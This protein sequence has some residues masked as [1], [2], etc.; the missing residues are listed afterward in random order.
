MPQEQK[1]TQQQPGPAG[2]RRCARLRAPSHVVR[3]EGVAPSHSLNGRRVPAPPIL[4]VPTRQ[5]AAAVRPQQHLP[6]V[7]VGPRSCQGNTRPRTAAA[8]RRSALKADAQPAG[9]VVAVDQQL[10]ARHGGEPTGIGRA[11]G[12]EATRVG[13]RGVDAGRERTRGGGHARE[14]PVIG[15][16]GAHPHLERR[17]V[18][19][20]PEVDR[21][22]EHGTGSVRHHRRDGEVETGHRCAPVGAEVGLEGPL[23]QLGCL[24]HVVTGHRR[25]HTDAQR[26]GRAARSQSR[27]SDS[28]SREQSWRYGGRVATVAAVAHGCDQREV[29]S[30]MSASSVRSPRRARQP[31]QPRRRWPRPWRLRSALR[32]PG[33]RTGQRRETPNALRPFLPEQPRTFPPPTATFTVNTTNDTHAANPAGGRVRGQRGPVL[34]PGRRSRW[35]TPSARA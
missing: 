18:S 7:L 25:H 10:V 15:R 16:V 6:W 2:Q 3:L 35:P 19:P 20:T 30:P 5:V 34:D 24:Q 28:V 14:E 12:M 1:A 13:R 29:V 33:R 21:V 32:R 9:G 23:D 22:P 8:R 26:R 27:T 31:L 17:V 4:M 11:E